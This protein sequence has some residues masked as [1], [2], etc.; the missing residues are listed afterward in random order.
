MLSPAFSATL[1]GSPVKHGDKWLPQDKAVKVLITGSSGLI[2]SALIDCLSANGHE[3]IRLLRSNSTG[4]QPSWNPE[5]GIID[6]ADVEN[7]AAVVH[8]AGDN[9][10]TS[11]WNDR[12]KACIL[13][14][15]VRGTKL[16]AEFFAALENKPRVIVSGSAIGVYGD[17]G[18]ELVD[19]TSGLG[20]GFLADVGKQWEASTTAAVDAGIRVVNARFGIVLSASGGA[21]AKMLLPFRLG[22][23]GAIGS[24]KQYMSW[25]GIDDVVEMIQYLI[26]NESIRGPVNLVSPNAVT[27]REFTETL[28]RAVH[29]PT[30]LPVPA[31]AARLLLGEMAN[32]LLLAS[33]RVAPKKLID[34]G[35]RFRHCRLGA[36]LEHLLKKADG[37]SAAQGAQ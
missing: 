18:A 24:G 3:P 5:G 25:V 15:R 21:L 36:A 28:G 7:I 23:G 12:K 29:R 16:L 19:E 37:V 13:S 35:Y 1:S 34:S 31:F 2:G 6:L 4:S 33:T 26:L 11:R 9:I 8:L 32:E 22:L 10:A 17:R 30:V 20:N 27:N 14:S